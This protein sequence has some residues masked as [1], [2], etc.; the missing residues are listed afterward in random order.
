MP[1]RDAASIR[2][3]S[4]RLCSRY[5]SFVDSLARPGGNLT[6]TTNIEFSLVGKMLGLPAFLGSQLLGASG[7]IVGSCRT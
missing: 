4:D 1:C 5:D 6:G 3:H 2:R 7:G